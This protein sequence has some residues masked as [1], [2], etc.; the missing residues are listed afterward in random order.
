MAI[1]ISQGFL[2]TGKEPIDEVFVLSKN[3]MKAI[4]DGLMPE[5]YFAICKDDAQFY[6]YNK[7]NTID[8][9]TGKFRKLEGG[10]GGSS[11]YLTLD[12]KPKINNIELTGNKSLED[13]GIDF[14]DYYTKTETDDLISAITT[15]KLLVV[16]ELPTE[17]IDTHTIYLVPSTN[18]KTKNV[19]DE[20]MYI[21]N[22]WEQIGSTA[23]DLTDYYTKDEID[24]T[25]GN[26]QETLVSG[27]NIKTVNNQDI[28]GSGNIEIDGGDATAKYDYTSNIAVGGITSGTTINK[29]DLLAD[30]VK[31]MLVTTYYPTYTEPSATLS[32]SADTLVEVKSTI[33]ALNATVGYNA[34]AIMLQGVKQNNRGGNANK[35]SIST[36]GAETEYNDESTS[37][38]V[39]SVPTLTRNTKG[40]IV[41]TGRVDYDEGPQPKDSTGADYQTPLAA[42]SKTSSKTIKFIQAFYYGASNSVDVS[43]FTGLTKLV[44]EKGTKTVNITTAD[45]HLTFIYDSSYGDLTSIKDDNNFELIDGWTKTTKTID[46]L[47]YN[48]WTANSATTDTNAQ[49]TFKF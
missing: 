41:I 9:N 39:F 2:R 17:N 21:N 20:Y 43:D 4:N 36:S 27:T 31:Q 45:Q 47:S 35:F 13:L 34:G 42:G 37:S 44:Q 29:D 49:F 1:K 40:N 19:K 22:E 33:P 5:K 26:Y 6:L 28:L 48:I 12:N 7:E 18:P 3:E 46:G 16:D 38:G 24:T 8:E 10:S 32:Y 14:T 25:L 23:I 11:D 30:L 15:L